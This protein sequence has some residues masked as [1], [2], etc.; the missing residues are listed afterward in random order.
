MPRF[1]IIGLGR[2][3]SKLARALADAG[4]E[5]IAV[6]KSRQLVEDLQDTVT[7]AVRLDSTDEQALQAQALGKV[8]VAVVGIGEDFE[9]AALTTSLL[10]SLGVPRV[11]ARAQ[12]ETRGRILRRVGADEIV[13]PEGE[14]AMRWAH[15]LILP[16]LQ[17]YVELGEGFSLVQIRAPAKFVGGTPASLELRR[18]HGVTLVAIRRAVQAGGGQAGAA[19]SEAFTIPRPDTTIQAGDD[20]VVVGPNDAL[21]NLAK[22]S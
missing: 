8:D 14:S 9:S 20:L 13:Y 15:R 17:Q 6:D 21:A 4:A 16:K 12:T 2:F 5:V 7:L 1:A 18:R 10:K 11:I 3:G 19:A 22:A